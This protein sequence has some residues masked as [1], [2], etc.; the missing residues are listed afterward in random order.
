MRGVRAPCLCLV[1][2]CGCGSSGSPAVEDGGPGDAP[3]AQPA[4]SA[5]CDVEPAQRGTFT[6]ERGGR[7]ALVSLPTGY[8][9]STAYPLIVAF[10]GGGDTGANFRQ[11]SGV[12]SRAPDRAIFVYPDGPN[13]IWNDEVYDGDF[14]FVTSAITEV[15]AAYCVDTDAVFAFGFSWGGWA[16]TAFVCTQSAVA[17]GGVAIAGG[18]PMQAQC[19]A[20]V[21]L[22]LIHGRAD[23]AE[24]I[25]SSEASR[26]RFE[27]HNG[28]TGP[29]QPVGTSGCVARACAEPV[30][31]CE[32]AG[33]H[34][35]PSF[36]PAEIWTFFAAQLAR[37]AP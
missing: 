36:A 31:W 10:H 9:R 20:Q 15:E 23:A 5:G 14:A 16:T 17:R 25:S 1:I 12:E 27:T 37:R 32:H 11:W 3:T 2:L 19:G 29:A 6:I 22:M 28:C 13:G 21:P 7:R 33:P 34:E 30:V 8:T 26:A 18:G 24:P 4:R 35:I